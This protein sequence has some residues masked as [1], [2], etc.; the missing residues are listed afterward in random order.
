MA[1]SRSKEAGSAVPRRSADPVGC[2]LPRGVAAPNARLDDVESL[3]ARTCRAVISRAPLGDPCRDRLLA[4]WYA[5]CSLWVRHA[6]HRREVA[7]ANSIARARCRSEHAGIAE[8]QSR[9]DAASAAQRQP[10]PTSRQTFTR[11]CTRPRGRSLDE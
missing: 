8:G 1:L 2:G 6:R 5:S 3:R 10:P 4:S 9:T 7:T 11:Y